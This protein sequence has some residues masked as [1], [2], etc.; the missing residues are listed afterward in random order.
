MYNLLKILPIAILL[1]ACAHDKE[2][3]KPEIKIAKQIEYVIKIPPAELMTLP[4]PVPMIDVDNAK[5]SDV[6][7]WIIEQEKRTSSLENLLKGIASFF[8]EEKTKLDLQASTLNAEAL[9]KQSE[10]FTKATKAAVK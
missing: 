6:A 8:K 1:T 2:L 10:E 4:A 3:V 9:K 5:Q 7:K